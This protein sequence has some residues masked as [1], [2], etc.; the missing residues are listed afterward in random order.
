MAKKGSMDFVLW[1]NKFQ[2]ILFYG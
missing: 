1:L 2:W